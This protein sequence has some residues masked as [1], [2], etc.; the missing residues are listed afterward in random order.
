[1][2]PHKFQQQ[3]QKKTKRS[4][5]TQ[6]PLQVLQTLALAEYSKAA[7][8]GGGA[9]AHAQGAGRSGWNAREK[10]LNQKN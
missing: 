4:K 5:R 1:M 7:Y 3:Q 9:G 10:L 6:N 8:R 2:K